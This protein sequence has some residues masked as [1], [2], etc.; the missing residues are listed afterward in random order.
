MAR[1]TP[2]I[3]AALLWIPWSEALA[4]PACGRLDES[5]GFPQSGIQ[6]VVRIQRGARLFCTWGEGALLVAKRIENGPVPADCKWIDGKSSCGVGK[7]GS[8]ADNI[9]VLRD[10]EGRPHAVETGGSPLFRGTL[11]PGRPG[12]ATFDRLRVVS[13]E[14]LRP[15][16]G[17]EA[18]RATSTCFVLPP[19]LAADPSSTLLLDTQVSL[20]RLSVLEFTPA[21]SIEPP[22]K[23]QLTPVYFDAPR[24][25]GTYGAV[26]FE[27]L[28]PVEGVHYVWHLETEEGKQLMGP[29]LARIPAVG[30]TD[31]WKQDLGFG[32]RY[33]LV[34]RAMNLLGQT[35]EPVH[36][37]FKL[38][39]M[40][41]D[42]VAKG[43]PVAVEAPRFIR[44]TSTP[45]HP[46]VL[47][48]KTKLIW[49]GCIAGLSGEKCREAVPT[50]NCLRGGDSGAA[51]T[52]M[53]A[54]RYCEE[55]TWAGKSDWRLPNEDELRSIADMKEPNG[56]AA[57]IDAG[58]F[59]NAPP[60]R[61]WS[62]SPVREDPDCAWVV[63]F[64]RDN[65][66]AYAGKSYTSYVRCVRGES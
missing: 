24:M 53:Q 20:S 57:R 28:L 29:Y 1:S 43:H 47:D 21:R 37:P 51:C 54:L 38:K 9:Y 7:V 35:S 56:E 3:L 64:G 52:W 34:A 27:P 44:D 31:Y 41:R 11:Y 23:P 30:S 8:V 49:Q 2:V 22:K 16:L 55:L 39:P 4:T 40:A 46:T 59:P 33:V 32:E 14:K 19:E 17:N 48:Q 50:K 63:P 5:D 58:A 25:C 61:L 12:T 15:W 60:S 6:P 45:D 65:E 18:P 13:K 36:I 42:T 62:S 66:Q 10:G 26:R